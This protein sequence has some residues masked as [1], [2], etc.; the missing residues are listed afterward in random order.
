MSILANG[1]TDHQVPD[2]RNHAA[3]IARLSGTVPDLVR[4]RDYWRSV[5]PESP[6]TYQAWNVVHHGEG[7]NEYLAYYGPGGFTVHFGLRIACIAG[8]CRYSGFATMPAVQAAHLPAFRSI[9]RAL[10]GTRLVLLPEE[11]GP[12]WDAAMYS[13]VPLDECL[14]LIRRTWGEP[15][16]PTEVVTEDI[17][18]YYRRKTPVWYVETLEIAA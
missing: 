16:F 8:A 9:A 3:I 4:V 10:G 5:D 12:I 14:S 17:E 13:G 15:H 11:N 1:L 6:E 2:H 7:D 18:V